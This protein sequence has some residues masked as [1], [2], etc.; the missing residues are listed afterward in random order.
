MLKVVRG[1]SRS[2]KNGLFINSCFAHCQS[3]RQNTWFSDNSP[4]IG[5]KVSVTYPLCC[6]RFFTYGTFF[7]Y[8]NYF[9]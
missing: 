9:F 4:V 1:F 3:E 2:N 5:K 6:L 7:T 8:T